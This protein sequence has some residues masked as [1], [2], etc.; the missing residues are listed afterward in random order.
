MLAH[1]FFVVAFDAV[2]TVVAVLSFLL[3]LSSLMSL[4]SN[5]L[6]PLAS[7]WLPWYPCASRCWRCYWG[8]RCRRCRCHWCPCRWYCRCRCHH[9]R[10]FWCPSFLILDLG[11]GNGGV[12]THRHFI[13]M[14]IFYPEAS[15]FSQG[16]RMTCLHLSKAV[17]VIWTHWR[18]QTVLETTA[19][20]DLFLSWHPFMARDVGWPASFLR[21][22][23]LLL[24]SLWRYCRWA[25]QALGRTQF[26]SHLHRVSP[27]S[28][29]ISRWTYIPLPSFLRL[30][31]LVEDFPKNQ[32][33]HS[34]EVSSPANPNHLQ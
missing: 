12:T 20:V 10:L 13:A 23:F 16:R 18:V 21:R 14:S 19:S 27:S 9:F 22:Q 17:C 24:C 25:Y 6:Q 11:P 31:F 28:S 2:S 3:L 33:E 4:L 15:L 1:C 7:G 30:L 26:S 29:K 34:L 5:W 32:R 8:Y